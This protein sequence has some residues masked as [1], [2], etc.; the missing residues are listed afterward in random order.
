M[1]HFNET[2]IFNAEIVGNKQYLTTMVS[3]GGGKFVMVLTDVYEDAKSYSIVGYL[4]LL[5]AIR[6]RELLDDFILERMEN[7]NRKKC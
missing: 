7:D 2:L 5:D 3:A 6:L 4:N 1:E